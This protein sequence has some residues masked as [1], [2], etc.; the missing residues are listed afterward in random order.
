MA[1][2]T[3]TTSR[4]VVDA[5]DGVLSL[6]EAVAQANAHDGADTIRF[7]PA[8]D[9]ATVTLTQGQLTLADDVTIAGDANGDGFGVVLDGGDD[10][11][12]L[13]LDGVGTEARLSGLTLTN[14]EVTDANGGAVLVGAGASLVLDRC[15]VGD[16]NARVSSGYE[17]SGGAIFAES[18]SRVT[19]QRSILHGNGAYGD[20]GAIAAGTG[21]T[22]TITDSE[23]WGNASYDAGGAIAL[24]GGSHLLIERTNLIG[25]SAGSIYGGQGGALSLD[26][27]SAVIRASCL[28]GNGA[29]GYGGAIALDGSSLTLEGSTIAG[30]AVRDRYGNAMGG[31]IHADQASDLALTRCTV[32]GNYAYYTGTYGRGGGGLLVEGR[33]RLADTIVV[34][35]FTADYGAAGPGRADDVAGTIT[36][37]NGRNLLGSGTAGAI[38][39]DLQAVRPGAI[40]AALDPETGG[41]RVV[42]IDERAYGV[43]LR[44]DAA[45]PALAAGDPLLGGDGGQDG[46]PPDLAAVQLLGPDLSTVPS[47]FNDCLRAN[48]GGPLHGLDGADF[49]LGL[50]GQDLLYGD[51]GSDVLDGAAGQDTLRGGF[52]ADILFGGS[53]A[54]RL[55]GDSGV[56]RLLGGADADRLDGGDGADRLLGGT[57]N[58]L[59]DGGDGQDVASWLD[60]GGP[61]GV[62]VVADLAR[63][64]AA[65]GGEHDTLAR[66]EM[67][68]G[69]PWSDTLAGDERANRLLG[70]AGDDRL[71]GRGGDDLLVSGAGNDWLDGGAGGGDRV[72]YSLAAQAVT[73]DL[74]AGLAR[75]G[76]AVD[77]LRLIEGAIGSTFADVL[78]GDA[79]ANRLVGG[80][81]NDVLAG[82]LGADQ[83]EGGG[84]A[85]RFV[86]AGT[87]DSPAGAGRDIVTDFTGPDLPSA[88]LIDLAAIDAVAGTPGNDH[89][90]WIGTGA[91]TAAGQLRYRDVTD[92]LVIEAN[93]GGSPAPDLEIKLEDCFFVDATSF[94]L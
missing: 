45:N 38:E 36:D 74:A 70:G 15:E 90:T 3:V 19:I 86:Y 7:A 71:L 25:N 27:A 88:D 21:V 30:N 57:G 87:N 14:G 89:F 23:L 10:D 52:G 12:L 77:Q 1:S 17:A 13:R 4:D 28:A 26:G 50:A 39:G 55:F 53:G 65:R 61:R 78:R 5:H 11:R 73:L 40:F 44:N 29:S 20:G 84:G 34:G 22:V 41:G 75:S 59:M 51:R 31:G 54:D 56:D 2:L 94:L 43:L 18:G 68:E 33:L 67:L 48:A 81:G 42:L 85:D 64:Y 82:R 47:P 66:I 83:L 72:D 91:F 35:N 32:T 63:G 37:S 60:D 79:L 8:L 93:T 62:G 6:R 9:G 58:D 80:G 69:T 49:L 46:T 92:G 16:N 24:A 76:S